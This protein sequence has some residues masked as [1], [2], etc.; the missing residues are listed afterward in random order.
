[1]AEK[2]AQIGDYWNPRVLGEIN[3]LQAKVVKLKGEFDWHHHEAEDELFL[4]LKGSLTMRFRDRDETVG[5]GEFIIV[6][7]GVEHLPVAEDEVHLLLIE[8]GTTLNTGNLM[9]ERTRPRV[10]ASVT[11]SQ[12][13]RPASLPAFSLPGHPC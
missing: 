9:N 6:P 5:E 1:M 2:L 11:F 3:H 7:H 8:P 13:H 12:K 4:V 10:G